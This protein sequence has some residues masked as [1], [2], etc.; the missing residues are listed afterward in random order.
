M[1]RVAQRIFESRSLNHVRDTTLAPIMLQEML[2]HQNASTP[3]SHAYSH[4]SRAKDTLSLKTRPSIRSRSLPP[5]RSVMCKSV[6]DWIE[7]FNEAKMALSW[8]CTNADDDMRVC[9]LQARKVEKVR[10]SFGPCYVRTGGIFGLGTT[11]SGLRS[12]MA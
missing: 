11:S 3:H 4:K 9:V 10:E 8:N 7:E 5:R 12:I 1:K 2:T 6:C